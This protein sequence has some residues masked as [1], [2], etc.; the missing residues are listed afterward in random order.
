[1]GLSG[2]TGCLQKNEEVEI[3]QVKSDISQT[4]GKKHLP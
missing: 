3:Y 2:A 1:M 4:H